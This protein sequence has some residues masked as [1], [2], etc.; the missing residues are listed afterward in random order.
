M[1]LKKQYRKDRAPSVDSISFTF[2]QKRPLR[3]V[4]SMEPAR[5]PLCN[6]FWFTAKNERRFDGRRI[7]LWCAL[8]QTA[9][10]ISRAGRTPRSVRLSYRLQRLLLTHRRL[11][12]FLLRRGVNV[13]I[14]CKSTKPCSRKFERR[15]EEELRQSH[16]PSPSSETNPISSSV[17]DFTR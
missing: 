10:K 3:C 4:A 14:L 11:L 17:A 9:W 5:R 1:K 6:A 12:L 15:S 2:L 7:N 13:S 16:F 8:K